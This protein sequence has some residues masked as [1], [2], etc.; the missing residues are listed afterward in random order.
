MVDLS[1]EFTISDYLRYAERYDVGARD[2][3]WN[4]RGKTAE[5]MGGSV[6]GFMTVKRSHVKV[7]RIAFFLSHAF[8]PEFVKHTCGNRLCVNPN[9][10]V[11]KINEG[12]N[13]ERRKQWFEDNKEILKGKNQIYREENREIIAFKK[14]AYYENNKEQI[15]EN[16][17]KYIEENSEKIRERTMR[18]KYGLTPELEAEIL[19]KQK[20]RCPC[21]KRK[22]SDTVKMHRDHDHNLDHFRGFLCSNCTVALGMAEGTGN[23][24][25]ALL[26]LLAIVRDNALFYAAHPSVQNP[27]NVAQNGSKAHL[28]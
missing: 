16:G 10:I 27:V 17:K 21:C 24:E 11:E 23:P 5:S 1:T 13:K 8:L 19:K 6:F 25:G 14:H 7:H 18:R 26:G 22:F 4:W 2:E 3:C 15:R 28:A 20:Y 9:H 12:P